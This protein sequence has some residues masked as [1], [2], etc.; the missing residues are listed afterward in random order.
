MAFKRYIGHDE[1]GSVNLDLYR[2]QVEQIQMVLEDFGPD[3]IY[4]CNEMGLFLKAMSNK[5]LATGPIRAKHRP[6][7]LAQ[8]T[9]KAIDAEVL[10]SY[11]VRKGSSTATVSNGKL[12]ACLVSSWKKVTPN[13]IRNCFVQ[14]PIL[15]EYQKTRLLG[16][17]IETKVDQVSRLQEELKERYAGNEEAIADQ[18]A[19]SILN[20][21][22]M[23][24]SEG[25]S[26]A[27]VEV[28]HEIVD[29][30]QY[31][32]TFQQLKEN[33]FVDEDNSED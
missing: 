3:N 16:L 9:L 30:E 25:P 11:R 33:D 28:A 5:T 7:G 6:N 4:N 23:I 18:K 22:R 27:I 14:A 10:C 26:Q 17:E 31:K 29:R 12:W 20:Y 24:N 2:T 19:F 21:L 15:S 32:G 13:C 8:A 1:S